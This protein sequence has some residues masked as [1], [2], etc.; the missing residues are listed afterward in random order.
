MMLL[1]LLLT[2][3][4]YADGYV[5]GNLLIHTTDALYVTQKEPQLTTNKGWFNALIPTYNISDLRQLGE[6]NIP[7]GMDYFYYLVVFDTTFTVEDVQ[8]EFSTKGEVIFAEPNALFDLYSGVNTNDTHA[9]K[10]WG[11]EKIG[12]DSVWSEIA[13]Y[14]DSSVVIAVHDTGIDLGLNPGD[15][16]HED[17]YANLWQ[18]SLGYYGYNF[19]AECIPPGQEDP[20]KPQDLFGHGTH[21]S[22]TIGAMTNNGVGIAGIVGGWGAGNPGSKIMTIRAGNR[23]I[24][25]VCCVNGL[26]YAYN[27]G[28]DV[29]N[30]SWGS[31]TNSPTLQACVDSISSYE[32]APLLVASCGNNGNDDETY[33]ASYLQV[34]AVA[35]T[36]VNDEKCSFSTYGDWVDIS[37]PGG[38]GED[39]STTK[40]YSTMPFDD[41][42]YLY[43]YYGYQQEYDYM[44][45]TSMA[46]PHVVGL[47]G[48]IKSHFP[49]LTNKQI[50]GRI[51]GTSDDINSENSDYMYRLGAGRINAYRALTENEHPVIRYHDVVIEDGNNSIFECGET[52]EVQIKLKNWWADVENVSGTL[53]TDDPYITI[54]DS[55]GYWG[56]IEQEEIV[57]NNVNKF[58]ISDN[59]IV[60]R[61]AIF[62]LHIEA[63]S[64]DTCDIGFLFTIH[65]D[66]GTP[67][68]SL[69]LSAGETITTEAVMSDIDNDGLDE[70]IIGSSEGYI[71]IYIYNNANVLSLDTNYP[72]DCT[73]ACGDINNDGYDEI[74]A[75]NDN[76]DVFIWDKDGNVI[77]QY[78]VDGICKHTIVLEDV[79]GDGQLEIIVSTQKSS[80]YPYN[81]VEGFHIIDQI[82]DQIYTYDTSI[83]IKKPISV[84]DVDNDNK[85]EIV[86]LIKAQS[87]QTTMFLKCYSVDGSFNISESFSTTH[88]SSN[89][90]G[91]EVLSGPQIADID[92]DNVKEILFNYTH[93]GMTE[94]LYSGIVVFNFGESDP[95]WDVELVADYATRC[96]IIIGNFDEYNTGL[97]IVYVCSLDEESCLISIWNHSGEIIDK[98]LEY[99]EQVS[100]VLLTD[101]N[102]DGNQEIIQCSHYNFRLFTNSCL[103][104]SE[105]NIHTDEYNPF[106][107]IS[108]GKVTAESSNDIVLIMQDGTIYAFP[109]EYSTSST[110]EWSQYQNNSRNTGSYFQPIPEVIGTDITVKHNVVVDT[111]ISFPIEEPEARLIINPGN[112][113]LFESGGLIEGRNVHAVG[114]EENPI[115]FSGL[116]ADTTKSYWDG[117]SI[118][119][120][121]DAQ[122]EHCTIDK[123]RNRFIHGEYRE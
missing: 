42:F 116:C 13:E 85:K 8:S 76:G 77:A 112:E 27:N 22:G 52:A 20:H 55:C 73:P 61:T 71:Y 108:I 19:Y 106:E 54:E 62:T 84:S 83:R 29:V 115:I 21:V 104:A 65:V 117:I 1:G 11:L 122:F 56:N 119:G 89:L 49:G 63:D 60:P 95:L 35:A 15:P 123:C 16:I 114:T 87:A 64:M 2:A 111:K 32:D 75:A 90:G 17:L 38:K 103:E 91:Y 4:V 43:V 94:G 3:S 12:M 81:G 31:L 44:Q 113:I 53:S 33:P 37:A 86:A 99:I 68:V 120:C 96:P 79:T 102:D 26:W 23:L 51:F 57:T 14:G 107:S 109:I 105:W 25:L 82:T 10:L 69:P 7:Q 100:D 5:E 9:D 93:G 110:S 70:I 36:D 48:L 98:S 72:I 41:Q 59:S 118:N 24:P 28:A 46:C 66:T 18:D 121:D 67:L 39:P 47:A 30:M 50:R 101:M 97:E 92:E 74:V 88:S 78:L 34:I 45:G 58:T 6:N 40:I 80:T